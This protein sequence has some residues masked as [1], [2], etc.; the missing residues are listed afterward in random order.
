MLN[1]K[2]GQN[3]LEYALIIAVVIA[4]LLTINTYLKKGVQ[5][6]LK[7]STDQIG[8]QFDP[9]SFT[10]ASQ[11]EGTGDTITDEVRNVETGTTT[12]T[13]TKAET[14]TKSEYEQ[15]GKGAAQHY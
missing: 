15:W 9:E 2:R 5:G 8:K 11:T 12:S 6:R 4:A 10:T 7:E 13:I 14:V 3:T 1:N